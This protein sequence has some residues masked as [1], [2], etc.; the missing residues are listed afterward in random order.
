MK[1]MENQ[2]NYYN[3]TKANGQISEIWIVASN[4]KEAIKIAKEKYPNESYFGK[5]KRCYNGGVKG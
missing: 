1:T 4:L 3:I 2:S 5:I